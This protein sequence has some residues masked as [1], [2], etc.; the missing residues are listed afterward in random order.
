M[1]DDVRRLVAAIENGARD[2]IWEAAKELESLA[3]ETALFLISLLN[4]GKRADT[5][6]GA[7]YVLGHSRC[8][9]ART[10]LEEILGSAGEEA[11]VRGHAAEA[12]AYIGDK[13][14]VNVLLKHLA[15][16]D[17]EVKY[18]CI[19]AL[20]QIGD[21]KAIPALTHVAESVSDECYEKYSLRTEALDA[22]SA[23]KRCVEDVESP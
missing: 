8:A 7:A 10:S 22:M 9:C 17:P 19:F 11:S 6:A 18:W 13:R 23:I 16:E 15:D 3:T 1:T 4:S 2:D 14:S 20:G 21:P 5:R 12:L